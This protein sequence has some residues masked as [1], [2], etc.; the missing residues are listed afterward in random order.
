MQFNNPFYA[1][2]ISLSIYGQSKVLIRDDES[3]K[4]DFETVQKTGTMVEQPLNGEEVHNSDE[5][6]K[7]EQPIN[8]EELQNGDEEVMGEQPINGEEL[9][10]YINDG[11]LVGKYVN[12]DYVGEDAPY[13]ERASDCHYIKITYENG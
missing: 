10:K 7:G 9:H 11:N 12:L 2:R 5:E 4:Y 6:F 8:G 3:S 1:S 13:A